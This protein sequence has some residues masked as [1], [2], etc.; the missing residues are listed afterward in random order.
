MFLLYRDDSSWVEP[1]LKQGLMCLAQ[2][3]NTAIPEKLEPAT[4]RSQSS[5]LPL[6]HCTP[7]VNMVFNVYILDP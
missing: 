3:H 6:S 2:G 7:V 4:R 1:V 5:T